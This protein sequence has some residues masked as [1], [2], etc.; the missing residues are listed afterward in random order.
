LDRVSAV[1]P[2]APVC[3]LFEKRVAR[4][5]NPS[6]FAASGGSFCELI[7]PGDLQEAAWAARKAGRSWQD[8]RMLMGAQAHGSLSPSCS[9]P[10]RETMRENHV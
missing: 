2:A 1:K 6:S 7:L 3:L 5:E 8:R 10:F 9:W 4:S